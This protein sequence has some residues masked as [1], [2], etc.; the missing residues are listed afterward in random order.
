MDRLEKMADF[1]TARIDSYDNHMINEVEGCREG[2][3]KM[4][5]LIPDETETLLD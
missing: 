1:F 3:L 4:A 5:E 2:Y